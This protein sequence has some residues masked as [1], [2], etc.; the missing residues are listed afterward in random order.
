MKHSSS[1]TGLTVQYVLTLSSIVR[2]LILSF[3]AFMTDASIVERLKEYCDFTEFEAPLKLVG[4]H[5]IPKT[6]PDEGGILFKGVNVRYREGLPLVIEDL[7][8]NIKGGSKVAL[9]G[10][11][12][13]GKSTTML[14]IARILELPDKS[15]GSVGSIKIDGVD[16]SKIG[17]HKLREN[18][19]FIPQDPYMVEGTLRF[20]LDQ[21][22]LC[23]DTEII[24][25]LGRIN[26]FETHQHNQKEKI[27]EEAYFIQNN[28]K[29]S[30]DF[31]VQSHG[32]NL[33]L[34]QRQLICIARALLKK[35]K[36]L[37]MDEATASIDKRMDD[38]IQKTILTQMTDATVLTIAHRL[39]T[40]INYGHIVVMDKGQKI[41][42]GTVEELVDLKG[43]F[44]SMLE[45]AG[46][47]I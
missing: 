23:S 39:E 34:G 27:E 36:I 20:N 17:L 45:K 10:R 46:I 16:I 42:E 22:G 31:M 5:Q 26:F 41:E 35:T 8:L 18:I 44:Y 9:L 1:T 19:A 6:W 12:G 24:D 38:L 13:S 25:I 47:E 14:T 28:R 37:I 40:V 32:G 2:S 11:T 3:G 30:L 43:V 7:N 33:S 21:L 4:D 15:K 29:K